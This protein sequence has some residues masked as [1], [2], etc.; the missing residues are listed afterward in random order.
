MNRNTPET[1]LAQVNEAQIPELA[2]LAAAFR[3]ALKGYKGIVAAPNEA[4]GAE[5]L[6]EYL[7]AGFPIFAARTDGALCGYMVCRV[8]APCVWV[9]A[10]Y[11]LPQCRRQGVASA[12]FAQ[13]EAL[14]AAYGEDTVYNYVHPNSDGVIA[15]LRSRGYSVLNLIEVRKPYPGEK[16]TTEIQVAN[17]RFAY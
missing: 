17:N 15:F 3:A 10:L 8:D 1:E 4:D 16:L 14:A 12:L 11:V 7:A 6:R 9:E 2:P 13:A 5:E